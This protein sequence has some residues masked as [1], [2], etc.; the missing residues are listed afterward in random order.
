ML[1]GITFI[2]NAHLW[3]PLGAHTAWKQKAARFRPVSKHLDCGLACHCPWYPSVIKCSDW[4]SSRPPCWVPFP[5]SLAAWDHSIGTMAFWIDQLSSL[6]VLLH[7]E[8]GSV[9]GSLWARTGA[10]GHCSTAR[11]QPATG[12]ALLCTAL[13]KGKHFIYNL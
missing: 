5:A 2:A 8:E 11:P 3:K 6:W 9:L 10:L 4:R 12:P 13:H 1:S 7:S